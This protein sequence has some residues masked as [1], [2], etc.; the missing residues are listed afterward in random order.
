MLFVTVSCSLYRLYVDVS[1]ALCDV[2][3]YFSALFSGMSL[4]FTQLNY[5]VD[6]SRANSD[7]HADVSTYT[8]LDATVTSTNILSL[9]YEYTL[10]DGFYAYGVYQIQCE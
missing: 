3:K 2:L 4:N 6:H 5:S 8:L 1:A 7:T 9:F 10:V